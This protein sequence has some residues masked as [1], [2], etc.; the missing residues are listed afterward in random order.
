MASVD[1]K[2]AR[3]RK[4]ESMLCRV[5][6]LSA[7]AKH[8]G[9]SR[10]RVRQIMV[11]G[12]RHGWVT[13]RPFYKQRACAAIVRLPAALSIAK[14]AKELH[15]QCGLDHNTGKAL[16]Q[17]IGI[18]TDALRDTFMANKKA[19]HLQKFKAIADT[20][21]V[22]ETLNTSVIQSHR[23]G[24]AAYNAIMRHVGGID[25]ARKLLGITTS[26]RRGRSVAI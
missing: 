12:H 10:E 22:G 4:V 1:E 24:K 15:A 23:E 13:Y 7:V 14:S 3:A 8:L 17:S 11:D 5:G 6:T 18:T 25:T 26:L 21:G 2:M 19:F 20:L 16:C 9:I